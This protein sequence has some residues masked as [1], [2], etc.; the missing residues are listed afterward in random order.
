[1]AVVGPNGSGK[2]TLIQLALRLYDPSE[3]SVSIDGTDFR[4]VTLKSLRKAITV[5]FQ[6]PSVLRGTI[7]ENIRYGRPD[8]SNKSSVSNGASRSMSIL[9]R[10]LCLAVITHQSGP[11]GLG[12]QA[13]NSNVL[14]LRALFFAMR[15][16][17]C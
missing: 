2:S 17:C 14:H 15:L 1:M 11:E 16:F 13:D 4:D 8:A 10:M 3:G 5:V 6:A 12:F 7:S 9:S